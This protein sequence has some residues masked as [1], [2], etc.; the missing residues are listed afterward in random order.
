MVAEITKGEIEIHVDTRDGK[1]LY[2][3]GEFDSEKDPLSDFVYVSKGYTDIMDGSFFGS[4][5]AT[6]TFKY[7]DGVLSYEFTM[8]G[9]TTTVDLVK[10]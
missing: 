7:K 2:W 4:Q 5:S 6:K 3:A 1:Y 9:S 8:M 10:I